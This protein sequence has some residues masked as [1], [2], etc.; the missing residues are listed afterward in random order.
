[1]ARSAPSRAPVYHY[2]ILLDPPLLSN[3]SLPLPLHHHF[4]PSLLLPR[5]RLTF[6]ATCCLSPCIFDV[7]RGMISA[8]NWL[9]GRAPS[10]FL[11]PSERTNPYRAVRFDFVAHFEVRLLACLGQDFSSKPFDPSPKIINRGTRC[12]LF[13]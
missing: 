5:I 9:K 2:R 7:S 8:G 6:R 11:S 12:G 10:S 1:M 4:H 3:L 13:G